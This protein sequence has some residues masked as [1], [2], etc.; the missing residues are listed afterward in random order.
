LAVRSR[1]DQHIV[2]A[3]VGRLTIGQKHDDVGDIRRVHNTA[4]RFLLNKSRLTA[5]CS[6]FDCTQVAQVTPVAIVGNAAWRIA[7]DPQ[8][9]ALGGGW[10]TTCC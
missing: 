1:K 8:V 7:T 9:R 5:H 6:P 4:G 10:C 2:C 3:I